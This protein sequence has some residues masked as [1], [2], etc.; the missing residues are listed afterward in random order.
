M[1]YLNRPLGAFFLVVMIIMG[2]QVALKKPLCI[3]SS[4]VY[5]IDRVSGADT[6]TIYSCSQFKKVSFSRFFYEKLDGLESR[7]SRLEMVLGQLKLSN[8]IVVRIEEGKG[9]ETEFLPNGIVISAESL[10][11]AQFEKSIF[12]SVLKNKI[13][14]SD[15][16]Y[17]ETLAD[18]LLSF[19]G[20]E[21][22][23]NLISQ[24][25]SESFNNLGFFE[26]IKISREIS[27]QAI[28]SYQP[29]LAAIDNLK[30]LLKNPR[31]A[32]L[33]GRFN[34]NLE[35]RGYLEPQAVTASPLDIILEIPHS[36]KIIDELV[37]LSAQHPELKVAL[38]TR[39]GLFLLPSNI[40]VSAAAEPEIYTKY[41]L[42]FKNENLNKKVIS[43][44]MNNSERLVF[45]GAKTDIA[46]VNLPSLFSRGVNG[47][48]AKNKH[49]DFVQL[50]LPSYKLKSRD[51]HKVTDYFGFVQAKNL[52][53]SEHRALGWNRTEWLKD[54]QAFKP[55][56]N[57][58]VIQYYRIN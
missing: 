36:E 32:V 5:K 56:A 51:L 14:S 24:A 39:D 53:Q 48:L 52:F 17:L 42:V 33:S 25:W 22:Y 57:Y 38:K 16:I 40:Q 1:G 29:E 6:D 13:N 4:I 49:L 11:T 50:H 2:I 43:R 26:K 9:P 58:D 46:T 47:F 37:L 41:R 44:Y 35:K 31:Y 27:L 18:F 54:L 8:R 19:Q 15:R 45:M 12:Q 3:D 20:S 10:E 28:K 21:K 23:Q 34:K 30:K 55:L 7:I